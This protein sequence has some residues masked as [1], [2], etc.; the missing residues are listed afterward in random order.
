[1]QP[2]RLAA[3]AH[4]KLSSRVCIK[5]SGVGTNSFSRYAICPSKL[6]RPLGSTPPLSPGAV[7]LLFEANE[8]Q[9]HSPEKFRHTLPLPILLQVSIRQSLGKRRQRAHRRR[10]A[11]PSRFQNRAGLKIVDAASQLRNTRCVAASN[12]FDS[13][14]MRPNPVQRSRERRSDL[15]CRKQGFESLDEIA[16]AMGHCHKLA[17]V[18]KNFHKYFKQ[19]PSNRFFETLAVT[20]RVS[21]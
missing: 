20:M 7:F 14:T 9:R 2:P 5:F 4:G 13:S 21:D 3:I 10:F 1:M 6:T 11:H 19:P 12:E 8:A 15:P 17:R 18:A 16:C